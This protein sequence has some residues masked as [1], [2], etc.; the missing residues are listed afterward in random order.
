MPYIVSGV[1]GNER[2]PFVTVAADSQVRYN[3]TAGAELVAAD[4]ATLTL[5]FYA[6]SGAF[7][8][9]VTLSGQGSAGT[10]GST[11]SGS[12]AGGASGGGTLTGQTW[13]DA[14]TTSYTLAAAAAFTWRRVYIDTDNSTTTGFIAGGVGADFLIENGWLYGHGDPGWSWHLLGSAGM[15]VVGSG[16]SWTLART[17]IGQ[18]A[19]PNTNTLSFEVASSNGV[20]TNLGRY[21]Q[22]Y[23]GAAVAVGPPIDAVSVDNDA[24]TIHY[25][26]TFV[27]TFTYKNVFVDSDNNPGTGYPFGGIGVDYLIE[28]GLVY[29]YAGGGWR[30]TPIGSATVTGGSAGPLVWT[31]SRALIGET[32]PS[33]E[34][35]DL[36]FHGSGGATEYATP[37]YQQIYSGGA[38]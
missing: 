2:Y 13:N 21:V 10:G 12:G 34:R 9:Q 14:T 25:R 3:A 29:R 27:A 31:V 26:A 37:V 38:N 6:A 8:D 33:N 36:I 22:V 28:N 24:A 7:V 5:T 18:T 16:V 30:W 23:T 15:T 32:A 20:V 4:G 35:A 11:G 17:A 19:F 1:G